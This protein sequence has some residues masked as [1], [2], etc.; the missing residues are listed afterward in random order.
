MGSWPSLCSNSK[1]ECNDASSEHE[2]R[3]LESLVPTIAA[4]TYSV[5]HESKGVDRRRSVVERSDDR[6]MSSQG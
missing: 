6:S 3:Q 2:A 1:S 4:I 5:L